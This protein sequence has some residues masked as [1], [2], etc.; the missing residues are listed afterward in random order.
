MNRRIDFNNDILMQLMESFDSMRE[1]YIHRTGKKPTHIVLDVATF[2]ALCGAAGLYTDDS[3][4]GEP[5][6]VLGMEIVVSEVLPYLGII[7]A[8]RP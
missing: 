3:F 4:K 6:T 5:S 8:R 1:D 2:Q 7:V